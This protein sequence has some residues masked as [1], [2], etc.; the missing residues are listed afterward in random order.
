MRRERS[1]SFNA[2][3]PRYASEP[4]LTHVVVVPPETAKGSLDQIVQQIFRTLAQVIVQARVQKPG[5]EEHEVYSSES[6]SDWVSCS[7]V[8]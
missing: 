4:Q 2:T 5:E 6:S 7:A 8:E 1:P 3:P